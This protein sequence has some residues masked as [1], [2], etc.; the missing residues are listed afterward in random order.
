MRQRKLAL[1]QRGAWPIGHKVLRAVVVR[2]IRN[3]SAASTMRPYLSIVAASILAACV[4]Y[5]KPPQAA[6]PVPADADSWKKVPVERWR[7]VASDQMETARKLLGTR[8][9][10]KV[11]SAKA[12]ALTSSR[13]LF[14]MPWPAINSAPGEHLYLIRARGYV[15]PAGGRV[16]FSRSNRSLYVCS[17]TWNGEFS[18]P[19]MRWSVQDQPI[20]VSLPALPYRVHC[21]AEIGGDW[22]LRNMDRPDP[23]ARQVGFPPQGDFDLKYRFVAPVTGAARQL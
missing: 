17:V 14:G 1:R 4:H 20:I 5:D 6:M 22:I 13:L 10:V 12:N 9:A 16:R 19:G 2:Q 7:F 23:V 18:L 21:A 8:E 11:S 15:R 3:R